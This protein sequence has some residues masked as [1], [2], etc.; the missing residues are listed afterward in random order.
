MI[1]PLF[2]LNTFQPNLTEIA[3]RYC[4]WKD[5]IFLPF[6]DIDR[7]TVLNDDDGSLT[8]LLAET[9]PPRETL[10]INLD[11][12]FRA[13]TV[14]EECSSD[15]HEGADQKGPP[16]TAI[17]SPYEYVST[18][19]IAD[20]A[21]KSVLDK[22]LKYDNANN[23]IEWD[24]LAECGKNPDD[25]GRNWSWSCTHCYGAPLFRQNWTA[26]DNTDCGPEMECLKDP[27]KRPG[28]IS[29][30]GQST[31]QRSTLT[32]D[33]GWYYIDTT[34]PY[35]QQTGIPL[36]DGKTTFLSGHTYYVYMVYGGPDT[37]MTY[38]MYVGAGVNDDDMHV[39]K[40]VGRYR[41]NVN[42]Q[43]YGFCP[44]TGGTITPNCQND[45]SKDPDFL[46]SVKYDPMSGWLKVSVNL[47][48]Y[49][50]EFTGDQKNF[51]KPVNYCSWN[52]SSC[53]C[54]PGT[55]CKDNSVCAWGPSDVDCPSKG[56]FGFSFKIQP[57]FD[58]GTKPGPPAPAA[59]PDNTYWNVA[60]KAVDKT[61][62]GPECYYG[63]K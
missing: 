16:A 57:E 18:A 31:G 2:N 45:L 36:Q 43:V 34:V 39:E 11:E 29:M 50:T 23:C 38:W 53:G 22:C 33:Q 42:S 28:R 3:A 54:A 14:T 7:Q 6:N 4:T 62:S 13:P 46:T 41:V 26:Q 63:K 52:G 51:C 9:T 40:E 47:Q 1:E 24:Y 55:T 60:F 59:F 21:L 32:A 56:C 48:N 8:G 20:C 19:I 5:T 12:F 17:T 49:Q 10:S 61:I 37:Q 35:G 15:K 27:L 44:L 58:M 25:G 30:M